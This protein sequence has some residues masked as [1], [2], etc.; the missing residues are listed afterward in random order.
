MPRVGLE[1]TIPVIERRKTFHALYCER[2]FVIDLFPLL[3]LYSFLGL[4]KVTFFI[5]TGSTVEYQ[6]LRMNASLSQ[7]IS[8]EILDGGNDT[9][10]FSQSFFGFPPLLIIPIR[11][12]IRLSPFPKLRDRPDQAAHYQILDIQFWGSIYG[13][14]FAAYTVKKIIMNEWKNTCKEAPLYYLKTLY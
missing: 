13:R 8:G 5:S 4:I 6:W 12:H 1:P 7:V 14:H 2:P 11:L 3:S 9:R 10:G